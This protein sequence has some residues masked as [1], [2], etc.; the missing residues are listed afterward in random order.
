[1]RERP[2]VNVPDIGEIRPV[3]GIDPHPASRIGLVDIH[4]VTQ[5]AQPMTPVIDAADIRECGTIEC[6]GS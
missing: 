5:N 4:T 6:I 3:K 1:M 2:V